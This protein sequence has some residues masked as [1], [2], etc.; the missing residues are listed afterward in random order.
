R[1]DSPLGWILLA[2]AVGAL[3][4][5]VATLHARRRQRI[6]LEAGGRRAAAANEDASAL[7]RLAD[8]AERAGELDAAYRLRFRA[9]LLRLKDAGAISYR[10]SLTNRQLVRLV[11][12]PAF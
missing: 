6:V 11:R 4:L 3:A 9:G 8:R 1:L 10:S 12:A 2:I 5:A 7:E